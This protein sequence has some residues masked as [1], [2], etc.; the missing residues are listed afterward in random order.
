MQVIPCSQNTQNKAVTPYIRK[1]KMYQKEYVE[2]SEMRKT[3]IIFIILT[4]I[5]IFAFA[6]CSDANESKDYSENKSVT[7]SEDIA[8]DVEVS[9]EIA[10]MCESE[11]GDYFYDWDYDESSRVLTINFYCDGAADGILL[12]LESEWNDMTASIDELCLMSYNMAQD[13]TPPFDVVF[14]VLNDYNTDNV[15]YSTFNGETI[16]DAMYE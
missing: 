8:D 14:N 12:G 2:V 11:L 13:A 4:I 15:L 16:Y 5:A 9:E 1:G 7:T 10:Y 6:G 3:R